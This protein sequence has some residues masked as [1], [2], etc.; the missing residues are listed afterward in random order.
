MSEPHPEIEDGPQGAEPLR[1]DHREGSLS[2]WTTGSGASQGQVVRVACD[3]TRR[4]IIPERTFPQSVQPDCCACGTSSLASPERLLQTQPHS[5]PLSLPLNFNSIQPQTCVRLSR[6]QRTESCPGHMGH[7]SS[8]P[9]DQMP[10]PQGCVNL[11]QW[12]FHRNE[13]PHDFAGVKGMAW[14]NHARLCPS[15]PS[16][17]CG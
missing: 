3:A 15:S 6:C 8:Y 13:V 14:H 9:M 1:M 12:Q 10:E 17:W 7:Q 16:V 4:H 5:D 11:K 2:G